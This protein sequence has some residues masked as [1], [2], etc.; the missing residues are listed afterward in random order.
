M[1]TGWVKSGSKWY[2][3]NTDGSMVANKWIKSGGYDYYMKAAG[4]MATN[5][6]CKGY[7]LNKDGKWTYKAKASWV[8]TNK[9]WQYKDTKGWVATNCVL[10][11]DG[12]RYV[13]T[14]SGYLR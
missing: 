10:T 5:E 8:K 2:Y 7:W 1:Q 6:Y 14:V 12:N 3:M 13:F 9:G 11:I 4:S